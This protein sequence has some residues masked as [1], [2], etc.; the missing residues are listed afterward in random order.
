MGNTGTKREGKDAGP[1][2]PTKESPN[3]FDFVHNNTVIL[4]KSSLDDS[5]DL[6][7]GTLNVSVSYKG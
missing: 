4:Q 2:S 3:T 1:L 6:P 5:L 7:P